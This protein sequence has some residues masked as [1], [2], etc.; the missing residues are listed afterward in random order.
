[1]NAIQLLIAP[2]FIHLALVAFVGISSIRSRIAAVMS[3]Q[4]KLSDIALD[5]SKW[6]PHVRKLGNNFDNQF[7]VPTTWYALC[8]LIVATGKADMFLAVLSCLFVVTRLIHTY[9]HTGKNNVQFRMYAFLS[10]FA[11]LAVMWAWFGIRL[12]LI[13]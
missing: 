12:L 1:M 3:G 5:S 6:P 4:T 9:I 11:T 8:G 13:G 10:G 2:I 7:D